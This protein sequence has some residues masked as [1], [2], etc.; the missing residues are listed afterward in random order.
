MSLASPSSAADVARERFG[1]GTAVVTGAAAGIG[2]G[3]AR[4]LAGI[5]MHVVVADVDDAAAEELAAELCEGGG[6]ATSWQVD[7]SDWAS[8]DAMADGVF[9]AHGGVELLINN[10]G[11]ENAGLLWEVDPARWRRVMEINVD[12]VFHG[13]RAFVPRMIERGTPA[14]VANLSSVAAFA[15]TPVQ[16]AYTVSK[17]AVLSITECL[18][19]ELALVEAPVQV[20]A[21]LPYSIRSSIFTTARREAPS[22]NAVANAVFD[23]MQEKNVAAGRDPVD[24]ARDM[25]AAIAR[26]EFWIFSDTE[27]CSA[28]ARRRSDHLGELDPPADPWISLKGLGVTPST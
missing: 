17:H 15:I 12:G 19:Q 23:A 3:F 10:A 2:A 22:G 13:V 26:G 18:H 8:V 21:V 1:G 7:V 4:H 5:G 20:S 28:A 14:T 9:A 6:R 25:T 27:I 11:V 24:A 16:A